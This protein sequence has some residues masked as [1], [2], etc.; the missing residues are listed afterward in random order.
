VKALLN[1]LND[2]AHPDIVETALRILNGLTIPATL[3]DEMVKLLYS[4][5][6][7]IRK[8]AVRALEHF[9]TIKSTRALL[10]C[11]N[12][13][14]WELTPET[15][16]ALRRLKHTPEI[17][18]GEVERTDDKERARR[19]ANV[20]RGGKFEVSNTLLNN[21]AGKLLKAIAEDGEKLEI[22]FALMSSLSEE[23]LARTLLSRAD[24]L[25]KAGKYQ[26]AERHLRM[27]TQLG[28]PSPELKY[29]LA[30]VRLKLSSK[31]LTAVDRA[32]DPALALFGS[33]AGKPDF[34][35]LK[36]LQK[37]KDILSPND[38]YY[39]GYHFSA[40]EGAEKQFGEALLKFLTTAFPKTAESKKATQRLK[41]K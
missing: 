39:V 18:L 36:R 23:H 15:M 13:A 27:L 10:D 11:L 40:S 41:K 26:Q 5:H 34:E 8:L 24:D 14:D 21:L 4:R 7:A 22:Y 38:Y 37:E 33:L 6:S 35:L 19:L 12:R 30:V 2:R 28:P 3:S 16:A 25:K 31:S 29:Q 17:I 1:L 20:L 9:G 32:A